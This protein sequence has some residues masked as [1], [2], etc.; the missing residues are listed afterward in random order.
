VNNKGRVAFLEAVLRKRVTEG[1]LDGAQLFYTFYSRMWEYSGHADPDQ[2]SP[3]EMPDDDVWSWLEMVF[4][5]GNQQTTGGPIAFDEGHPPNL[6]S[7]SPFFL[8]FCWFSSARLTPNFFP[9]F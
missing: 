4:K 8:S 5:M 1:A 9:I 3:E 6:V 2:A 7:F